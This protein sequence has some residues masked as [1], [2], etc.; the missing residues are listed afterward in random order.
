MRENEFGVCVW[1]GGSRS[2]ELSNL[3]VCRPCC[4]MACHCICHCYVVASGKS[5]QVEL[6]WLLST[7]TR[8]QSNLLKVVQHSLFHR[9]MHGHALLEHCGTVCGHFSN[10]AAAVSCQLV[11]V[12][13]QDT[14]NSRF[15]A[16]G[17][18][19]LTPVHGGSLT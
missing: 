10:P 5:G 17:Q 9:S 7:I 4:T 13:V 15:M 2:V 16:E 19:M 18:C 14:I 3:N 1:F 6:W 8:Q 12:L 11:S